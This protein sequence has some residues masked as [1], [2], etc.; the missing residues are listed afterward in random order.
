MS[1]V[2]EAST[3]VGLVIVAVLP[4][5][6]LVSVQLYVSVRPPLAVLSL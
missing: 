3:A 1:G 4:V 5:G 2:K 6:T